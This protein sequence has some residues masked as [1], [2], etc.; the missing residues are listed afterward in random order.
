MCNG[1]QD[2]CSYEA[3]LRRDS[4][5]P[6]FSL[7]K[8]GKLKC[9]RRAWRGPGQQAER[10]V[11][12][13]PGLLKVAAIERDQCARSFEDRIRLIRQ[14]L[15]AGLWKPR[16]QPTDGIELADQHSGSR[17]GGLTDLVECELDEAL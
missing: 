10:N 16:C 4:S 8:V 7:I 2:R 5:T 3:V 6:D 15:T 13:A 14:P 9:S 17:R 1:L 12:P 11:R